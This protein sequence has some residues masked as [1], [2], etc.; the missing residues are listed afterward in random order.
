MR[1]NPEAG[2]RTDFGI[3]DAVKP[4]NM[5]ALAA[6]IQYD[7]VVTEEMVQAAI[8]EGDTEINVDTLLGGNKIA[9]RTGEYHV[10]LNITQ[11]LSSSV[12][13]VFDAG[14]VG[15]DPGYPPTLHVHIYANV[16]YRAKVTGDDNRVTY[17]FHTFGVAS[18]DLMRVGISTYVGSVYLSSLG[19]A[20]EGATI[21][22]E[23]LLDSTPPSIQG[24]T[25]RKQ[26]WLSNTI[27]MGAGGGS[28][29]IV[30]LLAYGRIG[31]QGATPS[32][33]WPLYAYWEAPSG[34]KGAIAASNVPPTGTGVGQKLDGC[35]V[36]RAKE[37]YG[38]MYLPQYLTDS[39]A[40]LKF[41]N[42]DG[43]WSA[44]Q[45]YS[46]RHMYG[47]TLADAAAGCEL[48]TGAGTTVKLNNRLTQVDMFVT[49]GLVLGDTGAL[50]PG[51]M[52]DE[53]W[54]INVAGMDEGQVVEMNIHI[55][56]FPPAKQDTH[57]ALGLEHFIGNW[58]DH[59]V[60]GEGDFVATASGNTFKFYRSL[61]GNNQ[62]HHPSTSTAWWEEIK[63][64]TGDDKGLLH[65]ATPR[66]SRA[67]AHLIFQDN[68]F[69]PLATM[70]W[71]YGNNAG[72]IAG[73]IGTPP[74]NNRVN[75]T[76]NGPKD[77]GYGERL[78]EDPVPT[79]PI[80]ASAK[81]IFTK[82]ITGDGPVIV[83]LTGGYCSPEY[84]NY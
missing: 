6:S 23:T 76:F 31:T 51:D 21:I 56:N 78:L 67:R 71:G 10:L 17:F 66:N 43:E 68:D 80:A 12:T 30:T 61:Q 1:N 84:P 37:K 19:Q 72:G 35:L 75:V 13:F 38:G 74:S 28:R 49:L 24:L 7:Y 64:G 81:I 79:I 52:R 77:I 20:P 57:P 58:G 45:V 25:L 27:D 73:G 5:N 82:I 83:I 9:H 18:V 69:T 15:E 42:T 50:L 47:F 60:Y 40:A 32:A 62:A 2:I 29:A 46:S 48:T 59:A 36:Y 41:R 8:D 33:R 65:A 55:V 16:A 44:N 70:S 34:A 39:A 3:D 4:K 22:Y 14:D 54:G 11:L 63:G 53:E 26:A